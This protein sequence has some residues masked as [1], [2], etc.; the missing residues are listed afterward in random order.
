MAKYAKDLS[1]GKKNSKNFPKR[2]GNKNKQRPGSHGINSKVLC[3]KE[4]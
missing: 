3:G 1:E 2:K 4:W